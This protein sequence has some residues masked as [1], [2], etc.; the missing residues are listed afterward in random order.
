[1]TQTPRVE[2]RD[3]QP[4]VAISTNTTMQGLAGA[5]NRCLPEL[6]GWLGAREVQPAGPPFIRYLRID[7]DR[8][9]EI[10]IAVP[11][12]GTVQTD[13]EV[14]IAFLPAGRYVTLLHVGPYEDLVSANAILQDW[15][16]EHGDP[17]ADGRRF[18]V[19]RSRRVVPDR[20]CGGTRSVALAN[21]AGL[22]HYR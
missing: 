22:S 19:G 11:V 5:V 15:A 8:E 2:T 1:M 9:L 14:Q 20:S 4:Y 12:K 16:H 21:R 18:A 17:M 13:G 10:E 3:E 6:F 7:M